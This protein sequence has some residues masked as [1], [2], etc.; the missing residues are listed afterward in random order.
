MTHSHNTRVIAARSMDPPDEPDQ[1]CPVCT[2]PAS[3]CFCHECPVCGQ[4]G[5]PE[6]YTNATQ[7]GHGLR[8]T[9]PQAI[10]RVR[11]KA[12]LL[13]DA[14][15]RELDYADYIETQPDPQPPAL[16]SD[17]PLETAEGGARPTEA[18]PP[19]DTDR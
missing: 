5:A 6:C 8:L 9:K 4:V 16:I 19:K 7:F 10:A 17:Y 14:A 18:R 13:R 11:T 12:A 15:D 1:P 3:D 2:F